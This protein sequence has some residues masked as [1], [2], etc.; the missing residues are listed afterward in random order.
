M[1]APPGDGVRAPADSDKAIDVSA[2]PRVLRRIAVEAVRQAPG[3]VMLA[4]IA[5]LVS[6]VAS[7]SLPRLFG[8]AVNEAQ[9]LLGIAARTRDA[10][11]AS[12]L[13]TAGAAADTCAPRL[14]PTKPARRCWSPPAW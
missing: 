5:S 9:R 8:R 14:W 10:A 1:P 12:A 7:L 4:M 2:M 13:H 3:R 11:H 6:A